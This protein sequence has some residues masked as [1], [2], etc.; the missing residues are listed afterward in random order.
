MLKLFAILSLFSLSVLGASLLERAQS[1]QKAGEDLTQAANRESLIKNFPKNLAEFK[2]LCQ[3]QDAESLPDGDCSGL[4]EGMLPQ[5]MKY[6]ENTKQLIEALVPL[7]AEV[8]FDAD[9]PSYLQHQAGEAC[10]KDPKAFGNALNGLK[11]TATDKAIKF[12]NANLVKKNVPSFLEC[13]KSLE[14][15]GQ[16][17]L[18]K[19]FDK[20]KR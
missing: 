5:V 11:G 20:V 19:R 13:Q 15:A 16:A 6:K 3:S 4:F 17:S 18:A 8:E 2:E 9:A 14:N 7:L 12:L 10:Q 1:I